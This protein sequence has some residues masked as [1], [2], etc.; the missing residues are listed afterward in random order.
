[1]THRTRNSDHITSFNY[2]LKYRFTHFRCVEVLKTSFQWPFVMSHDLDIDY[3]QNTN[4]TVLLSSFNCGQTVERLEIVTS[5]LP[6]TM[7]QSCNL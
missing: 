7:I 5:S 1:M 3:L 4:P 6:F 2:L